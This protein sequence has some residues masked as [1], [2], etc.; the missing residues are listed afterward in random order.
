MTL[1]EAA[2]KEANEKDDE[3]KKRGRKKEED[4]DYTPDQKEMKQAEAKA[5]APAPKRTRRSLPA[6]S[7]IKKVEAVVEKYQCGQCKVEVSS[8]S[9]LEIHMKNFHKT[10]GA[11]ITL[12]ES[13]PV[14]PASKNSGQAG[15]TTAASQATLA[16]AKVKASSNSV[17]I[18]EVKKSP[19]VVEVAVNDAS[20]TNKLFSERFEVFKVFCQ[21]SVPKVDP[22]LANEKTIDLFL[23]NLARR[24]GTN[25][26]VQQGY[27][28]AV[29]KMQGDLKVER[30]QSAP[31][32]SRPSVTATKAAPAPASKPAVPFLRQAV[33]A[34]RPAVPA[35]RPAAPAPRQSAPAP[36]QPTPAPRQAQ[37]TPRQV[38]P[39]PRQATPSPRG[40][41]ASPRQAN[42]SPRP[43]APVRSSNPQFAPLP[44]L[45]SSQVS[46]PC[47][48]ET[49]SGGGESLYR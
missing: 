46:F 12:D 39:S 35:T 40:V 8:R 42:P 19:D 49:N 33:P 14:K 17:T 34:T 26:S 6:G 32:L 23:E 11:T 22:V 3:V 18:S 9:D 37:P 10:V 41:A 15:K 44:S 5:P 29:V 4:E 31:L 47:R 13:T 38:A 30:R 43:P 25:K 45:L 20:N 21:S 7:T 27:R 24:K 1:E 16:A 2:A 36:R 48:L 28:Q